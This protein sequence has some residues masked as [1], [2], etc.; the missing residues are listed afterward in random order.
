MRL[1]T[2]DRRELQNPRAFPSGAGFCVPGEEGGDGDNKKNGPLRVEKAAQ[3]GFPGVGILRSEHG[4][5]D[6]LNTRTSISFNLAP[7]I[8]EKWLR[9]D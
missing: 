2:L 3:D 6:A 1:V 7:L 5:Q 8:I 4:K 9:E